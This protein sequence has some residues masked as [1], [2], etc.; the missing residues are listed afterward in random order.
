MESKDINILIGKRL[1][2]VREIFNEGGKIS[3]TQFA[4][5]LSETRDRISNYEN[6][7][8]AVPVKLLYELYLRGINPNYI[9]SGE[10]EVFANN[11]AGKIFMAKVQ[12]KIALPNAS[13]VMKLTDTKTEFLKVAAGLI[14]PPPKK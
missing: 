6:G 10:G 9:I 1:R 14:P 2:E 11:D 3:T 4:Y 13:K 7:R 8:S 12:S 5:L